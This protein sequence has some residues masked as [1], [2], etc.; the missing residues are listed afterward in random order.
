MVTSSGCLQQVC[1]RVV[2]LR[3]SGGNLRSCES[4]ES[5]AQ[6]HVSSTHAENLARSGEHVQ[7]NRRLDDFV[8]YSRNLTNNKSRPGYLDLCR[9]KNSDDF[10]GK[11]AAT[12][13]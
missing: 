1:P 4:T 5:K 9:P 10:E 11:G 7:T 3:M 12:E 6:T 13:T 2:Y 8:N